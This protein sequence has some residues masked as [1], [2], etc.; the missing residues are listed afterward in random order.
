MRLGITVKII[1]L[2]LNNVPLSWRYRYPKILTV[3]SK[4]MKRCDRSI[5]ESRKRIKVRRESDDSLMCL[6]RS[7]VRRRVK[8]GNLSISLLIFVFK[9]WCWNERTEPM[10]LFVAH[11]FFLFDTLL[12][13][14]FSSSR[15]L[16]GVEGGDLENFTRT[17][18][19]TEVRR[20]K[21][22]N[23]GTSEGKEW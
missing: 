15:G 2:S 12:D 13:N 6:T 18:V 19:E 22:E 23:Y 21:Q 9:L 7:T 20:W 10:T 16:H 3:R 1:T 5:L 8:R 4:K 17:S 11:H 14:R